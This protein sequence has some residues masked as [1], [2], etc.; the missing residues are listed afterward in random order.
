MDGLHLKHQ[1]T[2]KR[3]IEH[4]MAPFVYTAAAAVEIKHSKHIFGYRK[5]RY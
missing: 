3:L 5:K 1:Q 4:D 2:L